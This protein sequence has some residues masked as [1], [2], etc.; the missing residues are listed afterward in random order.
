MPTTD[1]PRTCSNVCGDEWSNDPGYQHVVGQVL[2]VAADLQA[3]EL[4]PDQ[5][6]AVVPPLE[7]PRGV[8]SAVDES[9]NDIKRH[10]VSCQFRELRFVRLHIEINVATFAWFRVAVSE[11]FVCE[12]GLSHM[13]R[14]PTWIG[15]VLARPASLIV[16]AIG[17]PRPDTAG[18]RIRIDIVRDE[19]APCAF[20][21]V[22]C[23]SDV[24]HLLIPCRRIDHWSFAAAK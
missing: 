4:Q 6:S 17:D 22:L 1:R 8:R 5:M 16:G 23:V 3:P 9:N 10:P 21:W 12:F 14:L 15:R 19:C 18:L 20:S 11:Y 2:S 13:D 24:D 7:Y